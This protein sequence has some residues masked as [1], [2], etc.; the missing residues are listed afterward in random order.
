MLPVTT[1]DEALAALAEKL[2]PVQTEATRVLSGRVLGEDLCADRDSPAADVSAM[3]GYAIRLNDLALDVPLIVSGQSVPGSPPPKMVDGQVTQIFTGAIVP[4][5]ADA[6]IKRED[7]IESAQSIRLLEQTMSTAL[8]T[9]IRYAGENLRAG[10]TFLKS[11]QLVNAA[12]A[13][14][15]TNFG[16]SNASVFSKVR[17]AIVTTGD[18]IHDGDRL[19]LPHQIRNSNRTALLG[20]LD[21]HAWIQPPTLLHV[22][23]DQR[24]LCDSLIRAVA[25]HDAVILTGGVSAGDHDYVPDVVREIGGEVI[26]HKLPLRPG[27]PILGA[28]T[29]EGKLMLGLPGNP[30]SAT[31]GGRRFA[32]PL[33]GKISGQSSWQDRVSVVRLIDAG[34]KTLPLHWMRGV[35]LMDNGTATPVVGKGSGDL[36]TLA[37][38]D[39]FIEMP[40][41]AIGEGPWPY[42][43]W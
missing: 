16:V 36:V 32:L 13:A 8:G 39:G 15:M 7:T 35:R 1:P 33:L 11:G 2:T 24:E 10:E 37:Q 34:Q 14:A 17:V 20:L 28:A 4:E 19:P 42:R 40:P 23:D 9:N 5:S 30:V 3:D 18:E 6:V 38:T 12:Q 27:K 29:V 22:R 31:M 26:F 25:G 41:N 21:R 43:S